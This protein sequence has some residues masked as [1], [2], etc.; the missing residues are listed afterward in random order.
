MWRYSFLALYLL[1]VKA[2][3]IKTCSAKDS[4]CSQD[5]NHVSHFSFGTN[6]T[7]PQGLFSNKLSEVEGHVMDV[8]TGE[9][10]PQIA[11]SLYRNGVGIYSLDAKRRVNN[12]IDGL[13]KSTAGTSRKVR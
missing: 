2:G 9:V 10:P 5:Q 1:Y 6:W 4:S 7:L 12:I 8:V 13:S 11:G 3:D